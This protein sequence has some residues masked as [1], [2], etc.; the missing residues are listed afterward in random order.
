[1]EMIFFILVLAVYAFRRKTKNQT[2]GIYS[3]S[4]Q[5]WSKLNSDGGRML[6]GSCSLKRFFFFNLEEPKL[7]FCQIFI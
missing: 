7:F 4:L 6:A 1:M 5:V 2:V 3:C